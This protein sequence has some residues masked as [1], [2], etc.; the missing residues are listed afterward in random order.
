[1][2]YGD[3]LDVDV[4]L[5][6][7]GLRTTVDLGHGLWLDAAAQYFYLSIDQ[8]TGRIEDFRVALTW[9]PR[10]WLGVGFGYNRF[11]VDVR[12]EDDTDSGKLDWAYQGPVL[13]YSAAF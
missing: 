3:E 8:Y 11:A 6:V 13:F 1:M 2:R 9:Q 12:A 5:P 10:R 7:V 4:P